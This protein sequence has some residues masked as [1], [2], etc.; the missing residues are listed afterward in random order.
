MMDVCSQGPR[1]PV[2]ENLAAEVEFSIVANDIRPK[3]L[4]WPGSCSIDTL[5]LVSTESAYS[6]I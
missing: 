2:P 6:S 1:A 3:L 4:G 5:H